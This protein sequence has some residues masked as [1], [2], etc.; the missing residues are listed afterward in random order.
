MGR[1]RMGFDKRRVIG[2]IVLSSALF[3]AVGNCCAQTVADDGAKRLSVTGDTLVLPIRSA[4]SFITPV[5][6]PKYDGGMGAEVCPENY[7]ATA[8][9][10]YSMRDS[11]R[12]A[13]LPEMHGA[14]RNNMLGMRHLGLYAASSENLYLNLLRT[15]GAGFSLGYQNAGLTVRAG[16]VA[17]RYETRN[18]TTQFGVNG[19]LEYNI[20]PQWSVA[21]FGSIYNNNPYFSMATYPFV[22]TS[23]YGG[24]IRYQGERWGMKLGTRRYY[25]AFQHQWK[26]EPIVTPSVKLGKKFVLELPVGPLVQKSVEKLLNVNRGNGPI[27]MP[28]FE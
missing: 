3:F 14:L 2:K 8:M 21:L 7:S 19:F 4:E 27:I 24:W 20:S 12:H 16:L 1:K 17:N 13:Y 25:D 6:T 26:M 22:E 28:E 11:V 18:V 5:M 23:S 9:D 15:N 10:F